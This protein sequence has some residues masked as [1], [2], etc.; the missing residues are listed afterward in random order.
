MSRIIISVAKFFPSVHY[1]R[2]RH[3]SKH[4][5]IIYSQDYLVVSIIFRTFATENKHLRGQ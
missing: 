3:V 1:M 2:S 4:P 5:K